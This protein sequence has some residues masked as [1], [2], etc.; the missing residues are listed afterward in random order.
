MIHLVG[1]ENEYESIQALQRLVAQYQEKGFVIK[2]ISITEGQEFEIALNSSGNLGLFAEPRVLALKD[3]EGAK[4][5]DE[6]LLQTLAGQ[7]SD[8]IIYSRKNLDKRRKLYK[9][10]KEKGKVQEFKNQS[11]RNIEGWLKNYLKTREV[12]LDPILIKEL[13]FRVGVD[14]A[15]LAS[16]IDKFEALQN[17]GIEITKE[18]FESITVNTLDIEVWDLVDSLSTNKAKSLRL[19]DYL[20]QTLEYEYIMGL[21]ARQVRLLFLAL[22]SRSEKVLSSFGIHPFVAAKLMRQTGRLSIERLKR[23][24]QKMVNIEIAVRTGRLEKKLALDLL[25]IAF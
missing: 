17:E 9:F 22:N 4:A 1:G 21:L 2:S 24:Y 18:I 5:Q 10:F 13:I 19:L 20:S 14:Q 16:E 23:L 8:L 25:V 15:I 12:R 11:Q 7:E 3:F 6:E